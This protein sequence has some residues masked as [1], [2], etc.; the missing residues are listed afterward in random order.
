[1]LWNLFLMLI[2]AALT[3][4]FG[5]VNL[6][7][8]FLIGFATLAVLTARGVVGSSRYTR[9]TQRT[10]GFAWFYLRELV[11]SNFRM[12]RDVLSPTLSMR[13]ALVAIPLDVRTESDGEITLL[14][15]LISLTPGTLSVD[16]SPDRRVLYIHAMDIPGGDLDA[17]RDSMKRSMERRVLE[18]LR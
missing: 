12:A 1:M 6:G 4:N 11:V 9:R 2:W 5:P 16:L 18:V 10:L 8:G 15:N 13:P 17:F 7:I 14:A 3:N